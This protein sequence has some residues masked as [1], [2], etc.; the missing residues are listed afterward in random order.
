MEAK[1]YIAEMVSDPT[2]AG[3]P[4]LTKIRD[5]LNAVK[6]FVGSH[7][8]ADWATCFYQ[9][10]NRLA[11]L[12]LLLE[13]NGLSAYLLFL[14]FINDTEMNGPSTESEW[15]GAIR[16][17]ESFLGIRQKHRLSEHVIHV[18]IDVGELESAHA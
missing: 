15:E 11:H 3:E 4:S 16:L 13:L 18:F 12:Y 8:S 5:S 1:A 17:L 6:R 2:E 7:S 14:N 9:Y 10:T